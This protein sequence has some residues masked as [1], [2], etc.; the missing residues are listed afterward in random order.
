MKSDI[1]I[2]KIG[3]D[4]I[5]EQLN[6]LTQL[7]QRLDKEFV[8]IVHLIYN[9]KGRVII[10]GLGKSG[11]IGRKISATLNSTGTLSFFIHA[12]DALHGDLGN[13]NY[14]DIVL[15]QDN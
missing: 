10:I 1:D 12:S 3:K 4:L 14:E 8:E 7:R 9:C 15:F 13:I 5:S 11:I 6:S 2:I